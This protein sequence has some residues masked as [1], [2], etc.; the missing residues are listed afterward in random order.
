MKTS[1]EQRIEIGRLQRAI[2][3]QNI[4]VI[5]LF[6]G[7]ETAGIGQQINH[8]IQALDPRGYQ[9]HYMPRLTRSER[10]VPWLHRFWTRIPAKGQIVVFDH[11]WYGSL[12]F[13]DPPKKP[14]PPQALQRI[15]HFEH[16][17]CADGAI[18][19]KFFLKISQSEQAKRLTAL[20][21]DPIFS[22]KVKK[23]HWNQQTHFTRY[24]QQIEHTIQK[25]HMLPHAP[26]VLI[27]AHDRKETRRLIAQT[28]IQRFHQALDSIPLPPALELKPP[29]GSIPV[30]DLW[31]GVDLNQSISRSD[32][33]TA[34][35]TL[36]KRMAKMQSD[37]YRKKIAMVVVYEGWDAA[38]KGGTI[39]RL[40]RFLDPRSY[41]VVPIGA[42]D[43]REKDRHYLWR[44]WTRLPKDGS[45]T[46]FDRSWYGRL[47]VER[48]EGFASRSEWQQS[49][50]QIRAFEEEMIHHGIIL[51]KFWLHIDPKTQLKRFESRQHD[52]T[53]QWKITEEDWRNREQWAAY[54]EALDDVFRYTH[55]PLAPW[56]IL[57]S[58][59]KRSARLQ[60]LRRV[61]ETYRSRI[62]IPPN[63][64][65]AR[66]VNGG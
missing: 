37:L 60:A 48:V 23:S 49:F 51:V 50:A 18:I 47:L 11:S 66:T 36:Q 3:D 53:R 28:V 34:G 57:A 65:S 52:E 22:W 12:F 58:N 32:Y 33:K 15:N 31:A 39:R 27:D 64:T 26:W 29:E 63:K 17:L 40:T 45:I 4:P 42:P 25:T 5:I 21:A 46:I 19:M 30:Q 7:L 43:D 62:S 14:A 10:Q 1:K 41:Q 24:M 20:S 13:S 61:Y 2:K 8:L 55:T 38:G 56:T 59:C 16:T 6:E 44:F 35:K 9:V 54:E